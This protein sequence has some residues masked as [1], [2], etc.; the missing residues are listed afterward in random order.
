MMYGILQPQTGDFVW[1]RKT[2]HGCRAAAACDA[3][4][5]FVEG[6]GCDRFNDVVCRN[7]GTGEDRVWR[8]EDENRQTQY[9]KPSGETGSGVLIGNGGTRRFCV[10]SLE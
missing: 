8:A 6:R 2:L 10:P 1:S 5:L 3:G 7:S 4:L 9:D